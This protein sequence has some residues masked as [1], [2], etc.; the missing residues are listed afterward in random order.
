MV[1]TKT[2]DLTNDGITAYRLGPTKYYVVNMPSIVKQVFAKKLTVLNKENIL[3]WFLKVTFADGNAARKEAHAFHA[4]HKNLDLML[5]DKWISDATTRT[6]HAVEQ[7][8]SSLISFASKPQDQH[9]WES[10]GKVKLVD[11]NTADA[12]LYALIVN[13]VADIITPLLF[14]QAFVHNYP[15]CHEDLWI[16]DSGVHHLVTSVLALTPTA[17]R[18]TAA[19]TRMLNAISEWHQPSPHSSAAK[20]PAQ[21]GPIYPMSLN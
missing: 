21:N 19:R 10:L 9:V 7:R 15:E 3:L 8:A 20:I 2:R 17:R 6:A 12:D 18:A 5:R 13:F 16:F 1:P 11:N 4:S 14:G